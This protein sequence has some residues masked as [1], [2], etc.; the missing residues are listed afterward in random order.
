MK[1][2]V[3]SN[4]IVDKR[5]FGKWMRIVLIATMLGGFTD[6]YNVVV[7]GASSLTL[8]PSLHMNEIEFGLLAAAPFFGSPP[9]ALLI[10]PLSDKFGRKTTFTYT[11]LVF[12]FVMLLSAFVTSFLQLFVLRLAAGVVIGADFV[13]G[14]LLASE[15]S[16]KETRGRNDSLIVFL[17][18]VGAWVALILAFFLIDPLHQLQWRVLFI[19]G[20]VF[21]A[22]GFVIRSRMPE[23][24]RW[25]V[26]D[27]NIEKARQDLV[28]I[29]LNPDSVQ[30]Y[31]KDVSVRQKEDLKIL[32]KYT[33]PILIPLF[34]ITFLTNIPIA[35]FAALGPLVFSS[36][37]ISIKNALL[38]SFLLI[39]IPEG[40]GIL[41]VSFTT[42]RIGR[43]VPMYSGTVASG[44]LFLLAGYFFIV[45]D[46]YLFV[47]SLSIGAFAL[48]VAI[49]ET[50]FLAS[51]L[52][53]VRIRGTGQGVNIAGLRL[54]G[55]VATYGGAFVLAVYGGGS[56]LYVY[57]IF[58]LIAAPF[59]IFWL[60]SKIDTKREE[61]EQV[62]SRLLGS[63]DQ[64]QQAAIT[65]GIENANRVEDEN[66][67]SD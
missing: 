51:E 10:G 44:I 58:M 7:V 8:I 32:R 31:G 47:A 14:Y 24:P 49:T 62:T 65:E 35:G 50:Y 23:P 29:G 66:S 38:Y 16:R 15:Y 13:V 20:A 42:D 64:S 48:D 39:Q 19:I 59:G 54:G 60:G 33:F 63:N 1:E 2:T 52:Y 9:G 55:I 12:A 18:T 34:V 56:L 45:K 11:L 57:G 36:L 41:F 26:A 27:G 67:T 30:S 5:L 17:Q 21:P 53:P 4:E 3:S 25:S 37:H 61:L 28:K 40:L 43:H 6:V 46:S 22:V